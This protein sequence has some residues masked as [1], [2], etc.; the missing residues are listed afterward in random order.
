MWRPSGPIHMMDIENGYF[1]IVIRLS[2]KD[3][4]LFSA[5]I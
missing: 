3:R 2:L 5:N 4:G 1:L